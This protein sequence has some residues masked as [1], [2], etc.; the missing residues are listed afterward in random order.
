M[1]V[2]DEV[3]FARKWELALG[4]LDQALEAGLP[5][6][7][8]LA[9]AGYG[10]STE[11]RADLVSRKCRYLVGLSAQHT[12]WPPGSEPKPPRRKNGPGRSRIR[13]VDGKRQP[14]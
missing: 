1:G 9:D 3:V 8:V 10:D 5:P 13:H 6:R 7:L 11:F 12:V 14:I 4:L 2:P